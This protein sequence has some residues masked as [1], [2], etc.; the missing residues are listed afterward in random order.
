MPGSKPSPPSTLRNSSNCARV[1]ISSVPAEAKCVHVPASRSP[2]DSSMSFASAGASSGAAP[3]RPIPVSILRWTGTT[4]SPSPSARAKAALE[5]PMLKPLSAAA[6][7]WL[8]SKP[9]MTRMR[10]ACTRPVSS[11]ASSSVATASQVAPPLSAARATGTAPC[12]YPLALTTAIKRVPLGRWARIRAALAR[13]ARR[14]ISAQRRWVVLQTTLS[15]HVHDQRQ[16]W[17]QVARQQPRVAD[18]VRDSATGRS[19]D[20]DAVHSSG[21]RIRTLSDEGADHAR[22]YVAGA[23][24]RERRHLMRVFTQAAVGMSHQRVGTLQDDDRPPFLRRLASRPGS[25]GL[26]GFGGLTQQPCHLARMGRQ[27]PVLAQAGLLARGVGESVQRIG[28]QHQRTFGVEREVE[29]QAPRRSVAAQAWSDHP[30]LGGGQLAQHRVVRG[31]PDRTRGYLGHRGGHDLG[32][33][34]S[35]DR[36]NGVRD[37]EADQPGACAGGARRG[38][39]GGAGQAKASR[40]HHHRPEGAFVSVART[41]RKAHGFGRRQQRVGDVWHLEVRG[42]DGEVAV[43]GDADL[44]ARSAVV[45]E[46]PHPRRAVGARQHL[47]APARETDA[48]AIEAFDYGFLGRPAPGQALSVVSAVD[49]LGGC[50]DLVQEAPAG[51]PDRE[52]DSVYR[53]RVNTNSLHRFI[54]GY[55]ISPSGAARHL[56]RMRGSDLSSYSTVTLFAR[57]RGWSTSCPSSTATWYANS[58]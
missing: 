45:A 10:S 12:P 21:V 39:V 43:V 16:L 19:V 52:R 24:G 32:A 8:G 2:G 55:W 13:T 50:V 20:I 34:G 38:E 27:D 25:I 36:I 14:S 18:A 41:L 28:V 33:L 4:S 5:T 44:D 57:L 49:E 6:G 7:A 46:Q 17:Q 23:A 11:R 30:G 26:N 29:D 48:G 31:V 3:N 1:I 35:E 54:L 47:D 22:Q 40:Q 51:A 9:P 53:N 37:Q 15:E 42:R 56:P 58:C